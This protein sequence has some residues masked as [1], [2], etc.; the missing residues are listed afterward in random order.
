MAVT[1]RTSAIA[2]FIVNEFHGGDASLNI[3]PTEDLLGSGLVKSLEMMRLIEFLEET[4]AIRVEPQEMTIENFVS[5]EAMDQFIARV[6]G[7]A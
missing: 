4:F 1:T 6:T 7:E 2:H 5:L 3:D